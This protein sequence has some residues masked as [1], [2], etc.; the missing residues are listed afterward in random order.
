MLMRK[1][2]LEY[3]EEVEELTY[4]LSIILEKYTRFNKDGSVESYKAIK[5]KDLSDFK[6]VMEEVNHFH[7]SR[8][9]RGLTSISDKEVS[10]HNVEKKSE[11][12]KERRRLRRE[13]RVQMEDLRRELKRRGAQADYAMS[14]KTI[15][16]RTKALLFQ[17]WSV[18][19]AIGSLIV[20]LT[21]AGLGYFHNLVINKKLE[22]FN[23]RLEYMEDSQGAVN[24]KQQM[25]EMRSESSS[26]LEDGGQ[27]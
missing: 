25:S 10:K 20:A 13:L 24:G 12:G 8:Y 1:Y 19:V 26:R 27:R 4:E 5:G 14:K 11:G 9:R 17:K 23:Q 21:V 6:D 7:S 22:A 18:I 15:E 2:S 3:L 16:I